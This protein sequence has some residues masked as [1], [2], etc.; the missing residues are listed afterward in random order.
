M[1]YYRYLKNNLVVYC[2]SGLVL[3]GALFSLI[4]MHRYNDYLLIA[5]GNI[6]SIGI[7]KFMMKRESAQIDSLQKHLQ[8]EFNL[9]I[10]SSNYD[11]LIFEALDEMQGRLKDTRITISKFKESENKKSLPLEI[12]TYVKSY[13]AILDQLTYIESFRLP[14]LIIHQLIIVRESTGKVLL[15]IKGSFTMPALRGAIS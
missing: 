9:D 13:R 8:R 4:G 12:D 15:K 6:N 11:A 14:N 3:A 2:I 1:N 10:T 7:N 5:Q